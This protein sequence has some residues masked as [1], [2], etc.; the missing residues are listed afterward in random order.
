MTVCPP[1][2]GSD[3]AQPRRLRRERRT[4]E[5]MVGMYCREHHHPEF[6]DKSVTTLK[7][8]RLCPDCT[9]LLDYA[10]RR[11]DACRFGERKP[12]CARCTVHCFRAGEREDI[13]KVM[14]YAGPRMMLR[15]PY[16]AVRH[17]LDRHHT[18]SSL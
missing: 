13:R 17:L 6:R 8:D 14:R 18:P 1:D 4:V 10:C 5:V 11:I 3:P 12:T 7:G 16:L 9:A 2:S 15:H